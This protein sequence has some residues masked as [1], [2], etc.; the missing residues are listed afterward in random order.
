MKTLLFLFGV[1][2]WLI[3]VNLFVATGSDFQ[4][5]LSINENNENN[6]NEKTANERLSVRN[7]VL[8]IGM[9]N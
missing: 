2:A 8:N 6:E 5:F 3:L 4:E 9:K 7:A 1:A